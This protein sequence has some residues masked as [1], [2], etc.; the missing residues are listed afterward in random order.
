M[1]SNPGASPGDSPL[2]ATP[3]VGH[4]T[5]W[6]SYGATGGSDRSAELQ[7][8]TRI[9]DWMRTANPGLAI[10]ARYV[11]PATINARFEHESGLGAGPDLF[12]ATNEDLAS[13]ARA[14]YL[15]NLTGRI[16]P[17]LANVGDVARA[18]ATVDGK[19]Y[20]VPESV[21]ATA[22][23]YD[24][25]K[26]SKPL[27]TTDALLAFA[28]AGGRLGVVTGPLSGWG[29]YAAFGGA[30][31]DP[32]GGRCAATATTGV[33]DALAYVGSLAIQPSAVVTPVPATVNAAFLSG[34]LD[35]VLDDST[36][37]AEY[38]HTRPGLAVAP[39][40]SGPAGPGRPL[41]VEEG[42]AVNAS[43]SDA[44]QALAIAAAQQ[45]VGASAEQLMA[46]AP[47]HFPAATTVSLADPLARA[48]AG[49][50]AAGDPWPQV[51]DLAR[52]WAPFGEAWSKAVPPPGS[53]LPDTSGLVAAACGAM[54]AVPSPTP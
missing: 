6:H 39:F 11:D 10:D 17:T 49:A 33:A 51:P 45:M 15:A 23:F 40:P 46:I 47:G 13:E 43:A 24:S 7:G 34:D 52:S 38:E 31:L 53:A 28:Q 32:S 26:V 42:W 8:F 19:V 4:L 36:A 48:L 41:V 54:D 37:L 16:D 18:G 5:L 29:F 9:L 30:I 35:V 20:L 14:G 1:P 50:I 22:M 44:Q 3:L 2:P 27:A 21:A 12:I 25:T